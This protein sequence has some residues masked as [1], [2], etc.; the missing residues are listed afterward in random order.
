[1]LV[2]SRK[3]GESV[4]ISGNIEVSILEISGDSVKIG[5]NAPPEIK[6][7]R[8][9]IHDAMK[10]ET[11]KSRQYLPEALRSLKNKEIKK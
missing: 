8:R 11:S 1:M 3:K 2:L 6:V 10:E 5:F 4:I 9:E 7:Y